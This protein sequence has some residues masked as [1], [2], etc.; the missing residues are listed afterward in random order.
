MMNYGGWG[1]GFHPIWGILGSFLSIL[2]TV[3]V[4][5]LIIKIV[6]RVFGHGGF[7]RGDWHHW[8][9]GMRGGSALEILR[10]RYAKGEIN[11]EEFEAKKKDLME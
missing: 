6:R 4:I 5:V 11:K 8:R 7:C 1:Y 2:I 3:L 10:E 9:D